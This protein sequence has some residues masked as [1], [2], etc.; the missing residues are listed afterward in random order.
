MS[1]GTLGSA[2]DQFRDFLGSSQQDIGLGLQAVL[3]SYANPDG[4]FIRLDQRAHNMFQLNSSEYQSIFDRDAQNQYAETWYAEYRAVLLLRAEALKKKLNRAYTQVLENS[5]YAPIRPNES[6]APEA[7]RDVNDIAADSPLNFYEGGAVSGPPAPTNTVIPNDDYVHPDWFSGTSKKSAGNAYDDIRQYIN[8]KYPL[9]DMDGDKNV[10]TYNQGNQSTPAYDGGYD[11]SD[12]QGTNTSYYNLWDVGLFGSNT[13]YDLNTV[14][15]SSPV[16]K[17]IELNMN[18]PPSTSTTHFVVGGN[19]NQQYYIEIPPSKTSADS[20]IAALLP[21][22]VQANFN[23]GGGKFDKSGTPGSTPYDKMVALG[24]PAGQIKDLGGGQY[25]LGPGVQ[26]FDPRV[27][28]TQSMFS[29]GSYADSSTGAIGGI[30]TNPL[31]V[32]PPGPNASA[33]DVTTAPPGSFPAYQVG[34]VDSWYEAR[35]LQKREAQVEAAYQAYKDGMSAINTYKASKGKTPWTYEEVM[36]QVFTS[37]DSVSA[38]PGS[39]MPPGTP[40]T[41]GG[42]ALPP[43]VS[44]SGNTFNGLMPYG[45]YYFP[46]PGPGPGLAI[47]HNPVNDVYM[48]GNDFVDS[49]NTDPGSVY[50]LIYD[51]LSMAADPTNTPGGNSGS[52]A[53]SGTSSIPGMPPPPPPPSPPSTPPASDIQVAGG[54]NTS[55][56][57]L[58]IPVGAA[59]MAPDGQP[60]INSPAGVGGLTD[61]TNAVPG[62]IA[63][64]PSGLSAMDVISKLFVGRQWDYAPG[65][66]QNTNTTVQG[67]VDVAPVK[68]EA[69]TISSHLMVL[70]GWFYDSS[71]STGDVVGKAL[72]TLPP[73][74]D[75]LAWQTV[76]STFGLGRIDDYVNSLMGGPFFQVGGGSDSQGIYDID[77]STTKYSIAVGFGM[78]IGGIYWGHTSAIGTIDRIEELMDNSGVDAGNGVQGGGGGDPGPFFQTMK[79]SL[80]VLAGFGGGKPV[81]DMSVF[82]NVGLA[83]FHFDA[84][85]PIPIPPPVGLSF[86]NIPMTTYGSVSYDIMTDYMYRFLDAMKHEVVDSLSVYSYATGGGYAMDSYGMRGEYDFTEKTAYNALKKMP[87]LFGLVPIADMISSGVSLM[88][89]ADYNINNWDLKEDG[90]L[91]GDYRHSYSAGEAREMDTGAFF[92]TASFLSQFQL[93]D[94][95]YTYWTET[96]QNEEAANMDTLR[97]LVLTGKELMKLMGKAI[98]SVAGNLKWDGPWAAIVV[99]LL[100]AMLKGF[101]Q[102]VN[103][104]VMW[105][106]LLHDQDEKGFVT[107]TK[108]TQSSLKSEGYDFIEDERK[109]FAFDTEGGPKLG[110]MQKAISSLYGSFE[111]PNQVLNGMANTRRYKPYLQGVD[112]RAGR[113]GWGGAGVGDTSNNATADQ[114]GSGEAKV[115]YIARHDGDN[116]RYD[117]NW[118]IK[119]GFWA[120]TGLGDINEVYVRKNTVSFNSAITDGLGNVTPTVTTT[121]DRYVGSH[122]RIIGRGYDGAAPLDLQS[123][124]TGYFSKKY[125]GSY[126]NPTGS[127][128]GTGATVN[129]NTVT[130]GISGTVDGRSGVNINMHGGENYYD[131]KNDYSMSVTSAD[132]TVINLQREA[133]LAPSIGGHM[134]LTSVDMND[135]NQ[136]FG[137]STQGETNALIDTIYDYMRVKADGS[138]AQLVKEYRDVFNLGLLDDIFI[139]ASASATTGGG[140]TSSIRLKFRSGTSVAGVPTDLNGVPLAATA[141]DINLGNFETNKSGEVDGTGL[142][143]TEPGYLGSRQYFT[144]TNRAIMDVYLDSYFAFKRQPKTAAK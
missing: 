60:N 52:S 96:H 79:G 23:L 127:E 58:P 62:Q 57:Y 40:G 66:D 72:V 101:Q 46:S 33:Q 1:I 130:Y 30:N 85:I 111:T 38:P 70:P 19:T 86:L 98:F 69:E 124:R 68:Y 89:L 92:T 76:A 10:V 84:N 25:A 118:D 47:K 144:N 88:G 123:F 122:N 97:M 41:P 133:A 56:L 104:A 31:L 117:D 121:I 137:A 94:M 35:A 134:Q 59:E 107:S 54:S 91:S 119:T 75:G 140:I 77:G 9:D 67:S 11:T 42:P 139:S 34:F 135:P 87:D 131:R 27:I 8:E 32:G 95:S 106:L 83:G 49:A 74:I 5:I 110:I 21:T 132:G 2:G 65:F 3:S 143:M 78:G 6:Y 125:F 20:G 44:T 43:G 63:N 48:V 50:R 115:H 113:Q 81:G 36:D 61:T 7:N 12:E 14:T 136:R 13:V 138:N 24:I 80:Q 4:N 128:L 37:I 102:S 126:I 73:A 82:P 18:V 109:L 45:Y 114:S 142:L 90:I 64:N 100:N 71:G 116:T 55:H 17:D 141:G 39:P 26:F 15:S 99:G 112:G 16:W 29:A 28:P 129:G 51:R 53:L 108:I 103:E 22:S 105:D 93:S 120:D